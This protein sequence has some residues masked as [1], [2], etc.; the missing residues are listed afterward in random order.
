M[1]SKNFRIQEFVPRI[2]YTQHGEDSI[3]LI[4]H[5]LIVIAQW[6]RDKTGKSITINDWYKGG[7]FQNRGYRPADSSVG[8]PKSM[9]KKGMALDMNIGNM[10]G[11]EMRQLVRDNWEEL[12]AL[13]VRRIELGTSWLHIDLKE[14]GVD[15]LVEVPFYTK[16]K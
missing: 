3:N 5:R 4:D 13:G 11:D 9:H 8:A 7:S 16:P 10:T 14:T 6:L 2:E 1:V 12:K 15:H